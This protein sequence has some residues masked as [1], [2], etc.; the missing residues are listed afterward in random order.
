MVTNLH[1]LLTYRCTLKCDHCD[2]FG[3]P[4]AKGVL[5]DQRVYTI[6]K[7][8]KNIGSI[9]WIF[10]EGGEPFL[11]YP[12]LLKGIHTAKKMGFNVGVI[13]NG[14]FA[15]NEEYAIKHLIPLIRLGLSRL[16]V[17]N[18]HY[19]YKDPAS[20]PAMRTIQVARQLNLETIE[21]QVVSPIEISAN[22]EPFF[23]KAGTRECATR[24]LML[25]GRAAKHLVPGLPD[26]H[27]TAN[28][29]CPY[30]DLADP[31]YVS[32]D[33]YGYLHVC[34]GIALGNVWKVPLS[35]LLI[36]TKPA[37]HPILGPI[38]LGGPGELDRVYRTQ[39]IQVSKNPCFYCFQ[40]R[41]SL[42]DRFPQ[43]LAPRQVYGL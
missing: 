40:V 14:S 15:R 25:L 41:S 1:I 11:F 29:D 30:P 37:N 27:L 32:I 33:P 28:M 39:P 17:S 4:Q 42:L 19:H 38:L 3:S 9:Q 31:K 23:S 16:Y 8:A 22:T 13:T 36:D 7:E 2:V 12:L 20:S 18:D 35:D 21:V 26:D 5:S 34:Q 10:F 24:N 6:L 43:Y